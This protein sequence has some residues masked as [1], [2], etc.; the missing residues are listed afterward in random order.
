MSRRVRTQRRPERDR[1]LAHDGAERDVGVHLRRGRAQPAAGLCPRAVTLSAGHRATGGVK[2]YP[3]T[4]F[5]GNDL[6]GSIQAASPEACASLC[7][8]DG[9]CGACTFNVQANKCYLKTGPTR[10]DGSL[11][12][13]SG[14][15]Q[16]RPPLPPGYAPAQPAYPVQPM[17][18]TTAAPA[19][20]SMVGTPKCPGCSISCPPGRTPVCNQPVE[21]VTPYC[22]RDASCR[23][24]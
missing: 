14:V 5:P 7:V 19:F 17:A 16:S 10:F 23:C 11:A 15:I 1:R 22:A 21:G 3:G 12:A 4:D 24:E 9:R 2:M 18:P 8:A 13:V 6:G 20:C